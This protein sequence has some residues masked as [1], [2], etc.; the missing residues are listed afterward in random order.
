MKYS[1]LIVPFL[2]IGCTENT[3]ADNVPDNLIDS[4]TPPSEITANPDKGEETLSI[5]GV[6]SNIQNIKSACNLVDKFFDWTDVK[7]K[8]VW[9]SDGIGSATYYY[10]GNELKLIRYI[11]D[12]GQDP[13]R[14][15]FYYL[16]D[17]KLIFAQ[18]IVE[19]T[20]DQVMVLHS[21]ANTLAAIGNATP[22]AS[23]LFSPNRIVQEDLRVDYSLN[24]YFENGKIF[25][26]DMLNKSLKKHGK[27]E[28]EQEKKR[29]KEQ[30]AILIEQE[31][32]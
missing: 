19:L 13:S 5:T 4:K 18:L 17:G 8:D 26:Q 2:V 28:I 15:Y 7:V 6:Q 14:S 12:G 16:K 22:S 11:F 25:H 24:C 9:S 30:F 32:K 31:M 20:D 23:R 27:T 3:S 10:S 21:S 29:I 1:L